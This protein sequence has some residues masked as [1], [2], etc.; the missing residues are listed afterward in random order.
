MSQNGPAARPAS[1]PSVT[2]PVKF[3]QVSPHSRPI[4]PSRQDAASQ[5]ERIAGN[6]QQPQPGGQ[7]KSRGMYSI[8]NPTD[9]PA[10]NRETEGRGHNWKD[11]EQRAKM[12]SS[13]LPGGN[14]HG[15][16][17]SVSLPGTP[18]V[19][20]T[21]TPTG[22]PAMSERNSPAMAY[23]FPATS[24]RKPPSP[25]AMHGTMSHE[26]PHQ[27]AGSKR[28]FSYA[29]DGPLELKAPPYSHHH[30]S[31]SLPN[32]ITMTSP[33]KPPVQAVRPVDG[34]HHIHGPTPPG[35]YQRHPEGPHH[36]HQHPHYHLNHHGPPHAN[37]PPTPATTEGGSA[38]PDVMRR[39]GMGG[40]ILNSDGQQAYMTLP[41]SEIP[42]PVQVDY[43]Q[44]SKKADEKRQRNAKASTRHR[45]KKK[46]MQEE[47]I[48]LLQDLKDEQEAMADQI[49]S[50]THQRD[51]YR[52][53]R[54]RLREIVLR[55]PAISQH[56]SGPPS[57]VSTRSVNSYPD[58]SP[59][60]G[61][62]RPLH[63]PSQG[64]LSEASSVE[65]PAQRRRTDDRPEYSSNYSTQ[66]GPPPTTLP[67]MHSHAQGM[68]PR[69][70]TAHPT[71]HQERLPPLRAI[72]G[73]PPHEMHA[74]HATHER[75]PVTGDWRL[76]QP[77]PYETGWATPRNL[78]SHQR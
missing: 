63:T 57:P 43:S 62:P 41:G 47:N 3:E 11:S 16:A 44:A 4:Q 25:N 30:P 21:A 64:Y 54:N 65:R 42:I 51:F 36:P 70:M 56:A 58:H 23:P 33:V 13:T 1:H 18:G 5:A 26:P 69:P 9:S 19:S 10:N 12:H 45:R 34:R 61:A 8:L 52:E 77:R 59:V 24:Q 2:S 49:E 27:V 35:D 7:G 72:D 39:P 75:D 78:D 74:G 37:L 14:A 28:P 29:G 22:R 50:L 31:N 53:E 46:N 6:G 17:A 73:H 66:P 60:G 76:T 15:D 68:P 67:P 48:R 20:S 71:A 40:P 55:T 32:A 38:W